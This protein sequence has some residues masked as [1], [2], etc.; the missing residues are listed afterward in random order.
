MKTYKI[1]EKTFT[2]ENA[3]ALPSGFGHKILT[4]LLNAEDGDYTTFIATTSNMP[5]FDDAMDL[6]GQA[7]Y[8]ALYEIIA[9][10]I[11]EKVSLW[12]NGEELS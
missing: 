3:S 8:E 10:K 1:N 2:V 12:L 7:K 6:E 11:E 9:G 5:A 4:V